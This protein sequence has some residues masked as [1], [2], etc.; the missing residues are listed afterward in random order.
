ETYRAMMDE[1]F[2]QFIT[3]W[4]LEAIDGKT[5]PYDS[6]SKKKWYLRKFFEP[7]NTRDSR[8]YYGYMRDA[9]MFNDEQ[10]NTHSDA[11][12]GALGQGGGYGHVYNKTAT[13]LFSLQYVL[14]DSLFSEAMK[15]YVA[16]WKFAHPYPE[17][18][19]NSVSHFTH[20]DLNWFFDEWI[21]TTKNIDYK[22][23]KIKKGEFKNQYVIRLK[24]KGRMQMPIDLRVI[25]KKDSVYNFYIPNTW[26]EK[27]DD[28]QQARYDSMNKT[29]WPTTQVSST[30]QPKTGN[31]KPASPAGKPKTVTLPKWYGW[32]KLQPTYDAVVTVPGGIKNVIL[33]PSNRM[34]DINMLDNHKKSDVE[35]R[36][37]SHIYPFPSWR[38]YRIYMRP[39]VWWNAYDGVK[40]GLSVNGNLMGVKHNFTF[41]AWVNTHLAQGGSRYGFDKEVDKKAGWFSYRFDYSNAVDKVIKKGTIYFHSQWLDGYEM[42]KFGLSKIFPQNFTADINIKAF[43]RNKEEWRNYLLY[44]NEWDAMWTNG[45]KFNGSINLSLTYTYARDKFNGFLTAHV[46]SGILT[47]AFDYNYFDLTSVLR[48][49]ASKFDFRTRVY[50]RYGTGT[51]V[52]SESSLYFAGGNPE[53]MMDSKYYRAAGFVPQSWAGQYG[54]DVNHLQFGGGLNMRGY[55]G[56]YLAETDKN[57]VVVPAYKG[58]SGLALN[59]EI[60]FNRIVTVKNAWLKEHFTLNTYLFGDVGSIGYINSSNQQQLSSVRFDAG[61]G[62]AFTVKKWGSL[63]GIKPLTFRFDVPFYLSSTPFGDPNHFKFRWVVGIGRTF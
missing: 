19:R 3:V 39:D 27:S 38:K 10:L 22:I 32:D 26:F 17:D 45:H 14:G 62:L 58:P 7:T 56:Y 53:E 52:P 51:N 36:F 60:D 12:N 41:V 4:G 48:A 5:I 23:G 54:S 44:P 33:D 55:A 25:S 18:F 34:A 49:S 37:D 15:N 24:R 29:L 50:G 6:I 8:A 20:I 42:Y 11:F 35:F 30:P 57:K 43:T 21:E 1:G 63:Q 59:E 9:V 13:M 31:S 16:Q 61:A 40:L 47:S 46:R 28:N 2:T